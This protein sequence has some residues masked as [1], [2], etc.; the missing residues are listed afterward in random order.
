MEHKDTEQKYDL[1]TEKIVLSPKVKYK[2]LIRTIKIL[3]LIIIAGVVY[4]AA[5]KLIVP[6]VKAKFDKKKAEQD[7]IEFTRDEYPEPVV[8]EDEEGQPQIKKDYDTL[9]QSLRTKVYD[10]QKS[11]V[12]IQESTEGLNYE[13][14]IE[15]RE[16]VTSTAGLIV[17]YVNSRYIILTSK[18]YTDN[19]ADISVK[20]NDNEYKA[21]YVCSDSNTGI[22]I[23]SVDAEQMSEDD[24]TSIEVSVLSN[25]YI[26]NKG[27]LVIA[28]GNIYGTDGAV[29]Y[30]TITNISSYSLIDNNVDIFET[31]LTA[32]DEDYAFLFNS[33][34]N[35]VGISVHSN[36]DVKLKF[37]GI[38]DLKGT[39]ENMI[40][41]QEIMYF[42]IKAENV[43]NE[44]ADKYSLTT[45]IYILAV[46]QESPA[47]Q[48]GLQTGDVIVEVN[49]EECLTMQKLNEKL[50]RCQSGQSVNVLVKRLGKSGYFEVS[51]D[52]N[53]EYR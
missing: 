35:V 34:G 47:Y 45:G 51:Y 10:V 37:I 21:V 14:Y 18:K 50:Y 17:A 53:V 22:S 49:G 2:N 9:M 3:I 12:I 6:S 7:R 32:K 46:E 8:V 26:L 16:N 13:N 31:N 29:D 39:I 52:V 15:N 43:D 36:K 25:S 1:Y 19:T 38:S 41:R 24:R 20:V 4:I 11:V 5:D 48:A 30:G 40:N 23:I 44:L 42:G 33:D 28:A 27:E